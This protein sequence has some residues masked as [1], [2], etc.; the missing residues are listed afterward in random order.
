MTNQSI[1]QKIN[2]KKQF[3]IKHKYTK[4]TDITPIP[5]I[6]TKKIT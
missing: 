3:Y 6:F 5:T 2:D 4:T 1:T